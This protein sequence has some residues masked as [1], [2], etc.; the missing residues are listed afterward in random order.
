MG[1]EVS[2]S[3]TPRERRRLGEILVAGGAIS[4]SQLVSALADQATHGLPLGQTLL[5]LGLTTDEVMRQALSSQLGVPYI[6]LQNVIIDRSLA[7]LVNREFARKHSLFPVARIGQALT[8]AM[9]DPTQLA[10]VDELAT[11][12]GHSVT[13]VT[14][15]AEAIQRALARLY[16]K[17]ANPV[18]AAPARPAAPAA[19][20]AGSHGYVGLLGLLTVEL[21]DLLRSV[22]GGLPYA[23][24]DAFSERTGLTADQ[25]AVFADVSRGALAE[26]RREGRFTRDESD[27]LVRAARVFARVMTLF[28]EPGTAAAWL[29][30]GQPGL[31]GSVPLEL[32]RTELGAREVEAAVAKLTR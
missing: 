27:R 6:D 19:L 12:T 3:K 10:V 21:P 18:E 23:V 15:S 11:A 31:G 29:V 8:V 22:E 14:S 13:I 4:E 32:S 24:F 2:G 26:R 25:I 20:P 30:S 28:G 16:D 5:K 9:D 1:T 17:P 7:G